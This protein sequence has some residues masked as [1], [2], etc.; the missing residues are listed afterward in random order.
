MKSNSGIRSIQ[1][2]DLVR[3]GWQVADPAHLRKLRSFGEFWE[4]SFAGFR[5]S[6]ILDL[7]SWMFGNFSSDNVAT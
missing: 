1:L 4:T 3:R 7:G 2:E 6:A 5:D